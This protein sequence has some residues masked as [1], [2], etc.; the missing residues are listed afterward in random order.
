MRA[1]SH[2]DQGTRFHSA[3]Y[4]YRFAETRARLD[5]VF[6]TPTMATQITFTDHWHINADEPAFYDY[7]LESKS[8]AQQLLNVGT[9]YRSSDHDPV[10]IGLNLSP[11]PTTYAM[12]AAA[13]AW[14]TGG[15]LAGDD[16]DGDGV[17][18]L[19]DFQLTYRL[20][21][22]AV[23]VTVHPEWSENLVQWFPL[24]PGTPT[25]LDASTVLQPATG[26]IGARRQMFGRLRIVLP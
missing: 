15:S 7:N 10:L 21:A 26:P 23:G 5:H 9:P 12:W 22:N 18:N 17:K 2:A 25:A 11:Q 3:D 20:R 24:T 6:A 14:P 1:G 4:S 13:R 19:A 8:A 16:P